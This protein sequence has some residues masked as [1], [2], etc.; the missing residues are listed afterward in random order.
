MLVTV[1]FAVEEEDDDDEYR[2]EMYRFFFLSFKMKCIIVLM[3]S[4]QIKKKQ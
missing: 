3:K 2:W 1:F 4:N